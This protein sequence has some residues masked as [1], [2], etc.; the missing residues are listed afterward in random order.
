[1]TYYFLPN[2]EAACEFIAKAI[3]AA[4]KGQFDKHFEALKREKKEDKNK[5]AQQVI[6]KFKGNGTAH[7]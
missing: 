3:V 5:G 4:E 2:D 1:M 7:A 6:S